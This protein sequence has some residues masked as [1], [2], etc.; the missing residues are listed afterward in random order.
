MSGEACRG[1]V[2]HEKE[3]NGVRVNHV[4]IRREPVLVDEMARPRPWH[5]GVPS[6]PKEWLRASYGWSSGRRGALEI[7]LG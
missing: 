2:Q 5:G 6:M 7:R 3:R 1:E 4:V